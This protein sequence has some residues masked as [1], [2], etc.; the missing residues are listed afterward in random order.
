[1][2][3]REAKKRVPKESISSLSSFPT[4]PI[5]RRLKAFIVDS[6]MLLMPILYIVFYFIFGSRQG[7]AEHMTQGWLLVLIPYFIITT[8]FF[9]RT[10]QTPGYKAYDMML[11]D[12]RT[13]QKA[14]LFTLTIRFFLWL[15]TC[16]VIFTLFIPFFRKDRLGIY[17]ILSHTVPV[18]K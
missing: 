14:S 8:L 10:G 16:A 11:L 17:D 4:A 9:T 1:M 18:T 6:F 3:W 12:K 2:R 15:I 7:F 5:S 13:Q